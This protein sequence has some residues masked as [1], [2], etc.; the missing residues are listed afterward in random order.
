MRLFV[1]L[2]L[3]GAVVEALDGWGRTAVAARPQVLRAVP[4]ASLHLT[5]AFL[6]ERPEEEVEAIGAAVLG[7]ADAV[8]GLALGAPAWL[9]P[10]R[11]GVL[12]VDVVDPAGACG[13]LQGAVSAALVA[14]GA[15][16][17]ERRPFRPHVT[18]ARVRRGARVD[19][20]AL[21][22]GPVAE[23]F[24]GTALTVYRS[25]LGPSGARYEPL[26]RARLVP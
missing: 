2:D 19:R 15:C 1:A 21:P 4:A 18:V 17:P 14:L 10:R 5:L 22:P 24:S 6:G 26:A 7:C 3:P 9:P 8:P 25:L 20:G 11:P 12:A 23:P 13:R 16:S